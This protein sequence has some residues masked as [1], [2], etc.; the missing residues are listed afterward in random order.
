MKVFSSVLVASLLAGLG[1]PAFADEAPAAGDAQGRPQVADVHP[2]GTV[3]RYIVG[4]GGHVRGFMLQ[5]GTVVFT[6]PREGDKMAADVPV[7]QSVR[8]DGR[9]SATSPN[10]VHRASVYGQH[11]VVVQPAQ[12]GQEAA[13]LDPEQRKERRQ[14]WRAKR[15]EEL[16]KLPAASLEGTVQTV[17]TGRHGRARELILSNGNN[18]VLEGSLVK[19]MGGAAIK[20]GD[21]VHASGKGGT[22]KNGSAIVASDLSIGSGPRFSGKAL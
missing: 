18:I 2:S 13:N 5:D 12:R 10:V 9:A 15:A 20:A 17:V 22:Y 4:P 1:V 3:S 16:A 19:A 14:E 11:G 21:V 7:G 8:V 6:G